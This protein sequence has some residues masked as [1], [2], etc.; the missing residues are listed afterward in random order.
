MAAAAFVAVAVGA[1]PSA[2]AATSERIVF[3]SDRDG[4]WELYAMNGDGSSPTRLTFDPRDDLAPTTPAS[5]AR[6]AFASD[7]EDG[8]EDIY[9][10]D[11]DGSNVRRLT[12]D[13]MPLS[14]IHI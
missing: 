7:R 10:M 5:G 1:A 13:A 3:E 9:V 4:N 14:L 12:R 11:A 2:A 8:W 6:I